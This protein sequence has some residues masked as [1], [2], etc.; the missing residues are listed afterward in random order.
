MFELFGRKRNSDHGLHGV[1]HPAMGRLKGLS[2]VLQG[3]IESDGGVVTVSI[4]PDDQPVDSSISLAEKVVANLAALIDRSRD[5]VAARGVDAYNADWR[6]GERLNAGGIMELYQQPP[7]TKAEFGASLAVSE[8]QVIGSERV[9]LRFKCAQM[10]WS[11][12]FRVISQDGA[13]FNDIRV[14]LQWAE[15]ASVDPHDYESH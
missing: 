8:V 13:D 15:P 10:P 11:H 6:F 1:D 7:M 3:H 9:A 4:D 12:N 5:I 14:E 2:G